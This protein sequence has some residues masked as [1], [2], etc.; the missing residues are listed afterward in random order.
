MSVHTP[1]MRENGGFAFAFAF[2]LTFP[3]DS[4]RVTTHSQICLHIQ[5]PLSLEAWLVLES[6]LHI[7]CG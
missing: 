7:V 6:F 3:E 1:V 2:K 5:S 4:Q